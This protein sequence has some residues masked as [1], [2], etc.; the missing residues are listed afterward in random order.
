MFLLLSLLLTLLCFQWRVF[1]ELSSATTIPV[2]MHFSC[3]H[4][5]SFNYDGKR[6]RDVGNTCRCHL[7]NIMA[8]SIIYD[9]M[10]WGVIRGVCFVSF[11]FLG[12]VIGVLLC[13]EEKVSVLSLKHQ[14][15]GVNLK[16]QF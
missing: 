7:S 13:I 12:M 14:W 1:S 2:L 5:T 15:A 11:C 8:D 6:A 4:M 9:S 10:A 16:R 3:Y